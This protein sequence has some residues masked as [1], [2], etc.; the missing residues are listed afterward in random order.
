MV[1]EVWRL[2]TMYQTAKTAKMR[3]KE[4]DDMVKRAKYRKAH[5]MENSFFSVKEDEPPRPVP[6]KREKFMGIF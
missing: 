1:Y 5:G 4:T 6:E 3:Q 2:D